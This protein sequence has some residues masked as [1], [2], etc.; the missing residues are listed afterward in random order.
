MTLRAPDVMADDGAPPSK[1]FTAAR[2]GFS[3][4]CAVACESQDRIKLERVIRYMA[5]PPVSQEYLSVD[6]DGLV[7]YELKHAFSDGTTDILF[8]PQDFIA[9]LASLVPRPRAHL[10]RY[11]G[12]FAPNARHRH[13][14]VPRHPSPASTEQSNSTS[15]APTAPMTWMAWASTECSASTS[16]LARSAA[17]NFE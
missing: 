3:L 2:D 5:R 12:L 4:N 15:E 8:E 16:R 1:P 17:A 10:V 13:L 11:H 9:R 14:I 7:V 6:G